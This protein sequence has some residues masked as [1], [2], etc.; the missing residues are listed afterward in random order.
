MPTINLPAFDYGTLDL[1]DRTAM[2]LAAER[3][4]E[5]LS[6]IQ[7]DFLAI[8]AELLKVKARVPHGTFGTWIE[9][10]L[11]ITPRTALNYMGAARLVGSIPEP[12]RETVSLLPPAA[13]YKLAAPSTPQ[14][15]VDEMVRAAESGAL[16][17][18]PVILNRIDEAAREAREVAQAQKAKPELS[19]AEAKEAIARR[20][21]E[22]ARRRE[23]MRQRDAEEAAERERECDDFRS[24][25]EELARE[26][27][28]VMRR[29]AAAMKSPASFMF[30][31][32]LRA[33]LA[34]ME[35]AA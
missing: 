5:R 31:R 12:A 33:T 17:P 28:E 4:R 25:I 23:K 30:D 22:Q 21:K 14:V 26:H 2:Q 6:S 11:G 10:E 34:K 20:R 27:P 32:V 16:P 18:P 15:V 29:L 7:S 3:I 1:P 13:L 19:E 35:S 9:A 24:A 8:G